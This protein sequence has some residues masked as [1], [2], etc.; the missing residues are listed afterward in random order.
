L[1]ALLPNVS[2]NVNESLNKINL[3]AFGIP[4][5]AGLTSPVVGPF[6]HFRCSCQRERDIARL[7][8]H[9]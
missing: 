6:W 7:Q 8:C 4:L 1:S 2:G 5:P 3:A 9:Q